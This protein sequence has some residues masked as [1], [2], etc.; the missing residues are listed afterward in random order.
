MRRRRPMRPPR[1]NRPRRKNRP[2]KPD[3]LSHKGRGSQP[4]APFFGAGRS[5]DAAEGQTDHPLDHRLAPLDT[6]ITDPPRAPMDPRPGMQRP[7]VAAFGAPQHSPD[8]GPQHLI[9]IHAPSPPTPPL[10]P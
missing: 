2:T 7:S 3:G 1:S 6:A 5:V 9:A 10:P 8:A 4:P